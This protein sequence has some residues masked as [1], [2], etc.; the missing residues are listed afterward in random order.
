MKKGKA[1]WRGI[2]VGDVE[3]CYSSKGSIPEE[4]TFEQR[5]QKES[6]ASI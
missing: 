2:V 4:V 6:L 5:S 1:E 3:A